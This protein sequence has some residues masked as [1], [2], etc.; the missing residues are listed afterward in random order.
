MRNSK[1]KLL[2]KSL[3]NRSL[4]SKIILEKDQKKSKLKKIDQQMSKNPPRG[5]F[6]KIRRNINLTLSAPRAKYFNILFPI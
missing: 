3:K 5:F 2:K 4:N 1:N 6:W